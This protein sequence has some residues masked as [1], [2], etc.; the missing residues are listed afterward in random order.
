MEA[1][2][3]FSV[4]MPT[5]NR[6]F[7]ICNAINSLLAQTYQN[8]EFIIVDD[9]S[10]D[11]TEELVKKTYENEFKSGRFSYARH[12]KN[13]KLNAARNTGLSLAKNEWIVFLDDDNTLYEEYLEAY[14]SAIQE[15]PECKIF[16]AQIEHHSG[17]V[18]GMKMDYAII[19]NNNFIDMGVYVC[20]RSVY[21]AHGNFDT[22]LKRLTDYDF[23]LR[24]AR[25][26]KTFF[27]PKPL[28]H[29]NTGDYPRIYNTESFEE[30]TKIIH[31]KM[32][33]I[34]YPFYENIRQISSINVFYD[35]GNGF[36]EY[37]KD[38]FYH[39]PID[40]NVTGDMRSIMIKP[41]NRYCI[42]KDTFIKID[43][44]DLPFTTNAYSHIGS[45]FYFDT[46]NPLITIQIQ[47][48]ASGTL[49]C[50]AKVF[51]LDEETAKQIKEGYEA[52]RQKA[53]IES[54]RSWK[55]TKPLRFAGKLI[56]KI[57]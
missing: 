34:Y 23:I 24:T 42:V 38:V 13:M 53:M 41:C 26:E 22:K 29:Y 10:T 51:S 44:N 36:S 5:Y 39:F 32:S 52:S 33:R 35:T 43:N 45:A 25:I 8:F 46:D 31:E 1:K 15:N 12:E 47:H 55:I 3:F 27:I 4:I 2:P 40:I 54:S 20:N 9:C 18:M 19:L 17:M 16:Y 50:D 28:L 7:C 37:E 6:A 11:E 57:L 56:R 21:D 49:H 48:P 30:A 14:A